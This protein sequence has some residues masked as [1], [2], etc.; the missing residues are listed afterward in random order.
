MSCAV[1]VNGLEL[2]EA[3]SGC[4]GS[5]K[6]GHRR[7]GPEQVLT[8]E[9]SEAE[10]LFPVIEGHLKE[11]KSLPDGRSVTLRWILPGDVVGTEALS[12]PTYPS[13]V[14]ALTPVRVCAILA[15]EARETL[16]TRI[17]QAD[18][19]RRLLEARV[20]AMRSQLVLTNALSAD[21]RVLAVL[22]ELAQGY[23]PGA[24]FRPPLTQSELGDYLGLAGA[25]VSRA[26]GRLQD[27]GVIELQGRSVR[28]CTAGWSNGGP[29]GPH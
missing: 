1:R 2:R 6:T 17:D 11:C 18:A 7:L 22:M 27:R 13:T 29:A 5:P 4:M 9:G 24:W 16:K 19:F 14:I 15:S 12:R 25:T 21:E 8:L 10:H 28:I 23:A 3:C 26:F 20:E